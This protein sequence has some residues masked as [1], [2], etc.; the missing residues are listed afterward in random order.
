ML[1]DSLSARNVSKL[2]P[3][4]I[5]VMATGAVTVPDNDAVLE[6]VA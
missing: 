2:L 4:N 5:V 1:S 6:N 3:R